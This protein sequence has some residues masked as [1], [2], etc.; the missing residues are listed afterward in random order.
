MSTTHQLHTVHWTA[1][2]CT[3]S[4]F[5]LRLRRVTVHAELY[6]HYCRFDIAN[7][8]ALPSYGR[9]Q[10]KIVF[11]QL[12]QSKL[13]TSHKLPRHS[14]AHRRAQKRDSRI[15]CTMPPRRRPSKTRKVHHS[16]G[17]R[18]VLYCTRAETNINWQESQI[19]MF[20]DRQY[21]LRNAVARCSTV[22][23]TCLTQDRVPSAVT[24]LHRAC[25]SRAF[26]HM[27]HKSSG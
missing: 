17:W 9:P 5:R 27:W 26:E 16:K 8:Q 20:Q 6:S 1:V 24:D 3:V 18:D 23:L 10:Y 4:A 2:L 19:Y 14:G 22:A 7:H 21:L 25:H 11:L 13:F 15:A 12:L